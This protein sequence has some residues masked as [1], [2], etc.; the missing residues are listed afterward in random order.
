MVASS[1]VQKLLDRMPFESFLIRT[2]DGHQYEAVNPSLA[3]KMQGAMFLA[4][5]AR[6]GFKLLS[7][8]N[9]TSIESPWRAE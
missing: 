4:T 3:V 7:Y 9:M 1:E 5:P 6:D 2:A 8:R